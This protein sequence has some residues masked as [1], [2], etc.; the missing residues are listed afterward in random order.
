MSLTFASGP[1]AEHPA[2]SNYRIE[3]P[4][5]RLFFDD[6]PR[7]VRATFA[8]EVVLD[9]THGKLLHETG[10]LPQLYVPREDVR[11]A[12][13]GA[14]AHTSRCPW[15][16]VA[17]YWDLVVGQRTVRNAMW[18][19]PEPLSTAPWL[20]DYVALYWDKLDEW[21][22]E[23]EVVHGHLRDPYHRVDIRTATRHVEAVIGAQIVALSEHPKMLSETGLPNRW[24]FASDEV[25]RDLLRPSTT[26]TT[27]PYKGA[28]SYYDLWLGT[29]QITDVAWCYADPLPESR[30]IA[31]Y[32]CFADE[33][34]SVAPPAKSATR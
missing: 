28:A 33:Y 14:S 17:H 1:L 22:D 10:L 30:A 7:R 27:C 26:H 5:H 16:G 18:A 9:S 19:Y 11:M 3:G 31:G 20:A 25:R 24:Y 13:F 34:V 23:D 6:F 4:A 21:R 15:K 2:A 12:R 29:H 8:G 32:F